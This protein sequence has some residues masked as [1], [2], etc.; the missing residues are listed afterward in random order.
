RPRKCRVERGAGAAILDEGPPAR[1]PRPEPDV[2]A[3]ATRATRA[4]IGG[5]SGEPLCP[6]YVLA[7]PAIARAASQPRGVSSSTRA[8]GC[9][10]TRSKTSTR[11]SRSGTPSSLQL[12]IKV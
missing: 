7:A 5:T 12:M 3:A 9:V 8:A 1:P 11:Y 10:E 6:G 2:H 4:R